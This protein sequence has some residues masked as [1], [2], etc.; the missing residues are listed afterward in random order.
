MARLTLNF[1]F[2]FNSKNLFICIVAVCIESVKQSLVCFN[3][4]QGLFHSLYTSA[5]GECTAKL[6]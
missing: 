3:A 4:D 1:T 6:Q 5:H 2:I